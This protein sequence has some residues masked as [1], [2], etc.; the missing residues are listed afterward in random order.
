[1]INE[2]QL[3]LCSKMQ[4]ILDYQV[5]PLSYK[6]NTQNCLKQESKDPTLKIQSGYKVS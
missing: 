3:S 2:F 4:A 1:M 6:A 5:R